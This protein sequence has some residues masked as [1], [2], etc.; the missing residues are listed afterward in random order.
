MVGA[1]MRI[2]R[3]GGLWTT[4]WAVALASL[5]LA[6][7]GCATG[8]TQT[9]DG[10]SDAK[11]ER[12]DLDPML[13]RASADGKGGE[14]LDAGEVFD[15]AYEAF[16]ERR[17][18][19]AIKHYE[20]VVEYFDDSKYYLPAMYNAGLTHEKLEQWDAAGQY[21]ERIIE[22]FPDQEDAKHAYYRLS[23][24]FEKMGQHQKVVD[25]MTE[26]LLREELTSFDRVEAHLRRSNSLLAL[27]NWS[28]AADGFRTMIDINDKA[29]SDQHLSR[30]SRL[31]VQAH[32]GLGRAYH[33]QVLAIELVLPTERMGEDLKEKARL[34]TT[35]QANY[36]EALRHHDPHWSMAAGYMIGKLYEDFYADI[37]NAEIP[38]DLDEEHVALYFEELRTHIRPLMERAIQVYEKNLSLSRRM[39]TGED[40]NEWVAQTSIKLDRLQS[41]L[42]DPIAQRRAERLVA[43]G[44]AVSS[45]W[46]PQSTALDLVD[47]AIQEAAEEAIEESAEAL[48][49]DGE[50]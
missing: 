16:S 47:I 12:L 13:I 7:A 25:L 30:D 40:Q 48:G 1:Q 33:E 28:E 4:A 27:E 22:E 29:P 3:R 31:I 24:A 42:D 20:L 34:F 15:R 41:F 18:E 49:G 46:D 43:Q 36:I 45:P 37:F 23:N 11:E 19:Q 17:Y 8:S 6:A 26:V 50:G 14:T 9:L 32:F 38:D 44:R 35:A 10:S 5:M 21:Y 39:G 2:R